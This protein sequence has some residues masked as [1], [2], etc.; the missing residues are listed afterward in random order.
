LTEQAYFVI[1]GNNRRWGLKLGRD[2][3]Y[4][5]AGSDHLLL[6]HAQRGIDQVSFRVRWVWGS[7]TALVGQIDD[8]RDQ[9]GERTSRFLSG[10]RLELIPWNWLRIGI[11]ETLLFTGD[12]RFGSMNPFLPYYSELVNENSEGNGLISLDFSAFPLRG[13]EAYGELLLDDFQL[14]D[15]NPADLEPTEWG[16]LIGGRWNGYNGFLGA[17]ISY[18]G[19]TNRTYNS[20]EPKYRYLNYGL[21]LGSDIGNDGDRLN[22]EISCLPEAKLRIGTFFSYARQGEGGISAPFDTTYMQNSVDEGYSEP[23]PSGVV[24][25]TRTMGVNLSL[26]PSSFLQLQGWIGYDWIDD[27]QHISGLKEEGI[28]GRVTLNIRKEKLLR[29]N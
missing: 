8:F 9:E 29:I 12:L 28:R 2:H 5:G 10:H 13:L 4:W 14:E 19:V 11:S 21:P 27:Y 6:N 22:I 1:E 3:L 23:F 24:Q 16:W 18:G 15:N 17:G 25:K 7:F 26:L 20:I